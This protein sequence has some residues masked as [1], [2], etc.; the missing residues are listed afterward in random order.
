MSNQDPFKIVGKYNTSV[1]LTDEDKKSGVKIYCHEPYA[2]DLYDAMT[3]HEKS[4]SRISKDLTEGSVCKVIARTISYNDKTIYAEDLSSDMPVIIPFR[5]FSKDIEELANGGDREF[6]VMIYKSTKFG[7]NFGSEKKALSISY[8]QELFEHLAED[9]WF[10]VTITKLIKGGYLALYK[11]EIE[12]FIPGTHAAANIIHNFND[13][14]NK[15]LT[16]M[17]DNYD[18]ANDLFILSYKKY[19]TQSMPTM[20]ENL[21]FSKEYTGVLTS[22]PYDFGVFVEI[23]G[24]FTGLIHQSEFEDYETTKRTLKTGDTLSVY[25]KDITTK[26]SQFRIVLTLKSD[27][28]NSEKLAWQ[29]LKEKTQNKCFPYDVNSK[30]NSISIEIDGENYEVSLKRRDLDKNLSRYPF[31]KVSKVDMINKSLKFEFV[32][33]S[34]N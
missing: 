10:D 33:E 14:L 30:K 16:V 25:V 8:K 4:S 32:E 17:V 2:Q 1:K 13:M 26:G 29:N 19:V 20:I 9:Q 6:F 22:K 7:E 21:E 11:K 5:E 24:Y 12:C 31:V 23:D 27:N 3:R 18:Q 28:V 15:T 34:S